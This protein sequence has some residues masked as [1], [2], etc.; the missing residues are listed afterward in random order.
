MPKARTNIFE[1]HFD[2]GLLALTA[3]ALVGSIAYFVV[4]SPFKTP[5]GL[6]A[7]DV[8]DKVAQAADETLQ[9]LRSKKADPVK[10]P[11][12]AESL[13]LAFGEK[14]G[15]IRMSE[16]S[17]RMAPL[18]QWQPPLIDT[19]TTTEGEKHALARL[20]PPEQPVARAGRTTFSVPDPRPLEQLATGAAPETRTVTRAWAAVAAQLDLLE[21]GRV[22]RSAGYPLGKFDI[23]LVILAI[24]L[25]R[26]PASDANAPWED[27]EPYRPYSPIVMPALRPRPDGRL[28]ADQIEELERFRKLLLRESDRIVRG[29]LP[30][31]A[32]GGT[33]INYPPIPWLLEGTPEDEDAMSAA[34]TGGG[35]ELQLPTRGAPQARRAVPTAERRFNKWMNLFEQAMRAGEWDLAAILLEAALGEEGVPSAL[36]ERALPKVKELE[37]KRREAKRPTMRVDFRRPEKMMPIMACDLDPVPGQTYV[38]RLRYEIVNP[39]LGEPNTLK[40]VEDARRLTLL[41]DWSPPTAPVE[42]RSDTYFFVT[43]VNDKTRSAKVE[44]F[45]LL[46]GAIR[47]FEFSVTLGD[48]IGKVQNV[49]RDKVDFSTGAR[50]VDIIADSRDPLGGKLVYVDT[51]DGRLLVARDSTD[52]K[53]KELTAR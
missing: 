23:P 26:R 41:S 9:R 14:G 13:D 52:P 37:Q 16:I 44:V 7:G 33:A 49:A 36:R 43:N 39:F 53:Y 27:V 29:Q 3:L 40:D 5:E 48:S 25:Q 50:V 24:H 35:M 8:C 51:A 12:I 42:I 47:K 4:G 17:P 11:P 20:L 1:Q 31:V 21:Q 28:S 10:V 45:R 22:F 38:Y 32:A 46:R 18:V 15:L 2:K 6:S 30:P 19:S 34:P